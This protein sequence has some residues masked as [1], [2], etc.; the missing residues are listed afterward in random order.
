MVICGIVILDSWKNRQHW[1]EITLHYITR[2]IKF[3]VPG[4]QQIGPA[5]QYESVNY[6][7]K[8]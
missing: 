3:L 5:R 1:V 4:L 8:N 6:N 7:A 2:Y